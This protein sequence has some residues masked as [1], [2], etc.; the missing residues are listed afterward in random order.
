M[1]HGQ[2]GCGDATFIP[3][4]CHPQLALFVEQNEIEQ[5]AG[6]VPPK[7]MLDIL[8]RLDATS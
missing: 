1:E 6:D 7:V 2:S 3:Q 4:R 5:F 8:R